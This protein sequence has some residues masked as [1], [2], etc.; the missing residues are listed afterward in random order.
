VTVSTDTKFVHLA[1]QRDEKLLENVKYPMGSDPTG[2]LSRMFGVYDSNSGLDLRGAF[3][4]SPDGV[5]LNAEINFYNLG[6]NVVEL[7][8]KINANIHLA[9][10]PGEACPTK[11]AKEGDKTLKPSA[12]M[13]GKVYEAMNK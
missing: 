13:V 3:I 2:N 11:W 4:I 9:A 6:R 8:R 7:L 10:N 5:L 1:W 12:K